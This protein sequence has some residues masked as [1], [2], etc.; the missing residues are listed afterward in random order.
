[1]S[2]IEQVHEIIE[3]VE[4]EKGVHFHYQDPTGSRNG[5]RMIKARILIV[6]DRTDRC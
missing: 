2:L 4:S 3:I 6:E 1:M 5:D